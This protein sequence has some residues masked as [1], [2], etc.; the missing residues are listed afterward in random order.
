MRLSQLFSLPLSDPGSDN[1]HN[2]DIATNRSERVWH[3][4]LFR[5]GRR[6]SRGEERPKGIV[7]ERVTNE[8]R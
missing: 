8:T 2:W 5:G 7:N 6:S 4:V 1:Q 3:A